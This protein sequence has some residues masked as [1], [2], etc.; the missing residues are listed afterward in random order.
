M[1]VRKTNGMT[2]VALVVT[3]IVLLILAS[4]SLSLT[5]GEHGIITMAL[6]A[7]DAYLYGQDKEIEGLEG[8][9]TKIEEDVN[10]K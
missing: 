10:N 7:R 2:L 9:G 6:R 1:R 3:I 5:I 8:Q 4:T